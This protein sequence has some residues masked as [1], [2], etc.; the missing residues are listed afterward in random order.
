MFKNFGILCLLA[1]L[2]VSTFASR[3]HER[4][5]GQGRHGKLAQSGSAVRGKLSRGGLA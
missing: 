3:A 5:Q 4:A 1:M 2:L